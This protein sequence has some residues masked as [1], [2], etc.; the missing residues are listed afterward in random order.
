LFLPDLYCFQSSVK[1]GH[2]TYGPNSPQGHEGMYTVG[3][4]ESV[5]FFYGRE[6]PGL[7][8]SDELDVG[9]SD[10]ET[11]HSYRVAGDRKSLAGKYWY[12]GESNHVLFKTPAIEDDG[13]SFANSSEFKVKIDP[14][15]HG[16]RLRRRLDR[17]VNRQLANVYIDG[18][19]AIERPWYMVDYDKTYRDIRWADSDFEIPAKYT[20]GKS[21]ITVK[22]ENLG[23]VERPW[24]EFYYWV[25]SYQP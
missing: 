17:N 3:N 20:A 23:G 4:E 14:A 22:V 15:N 5:E 11:A 10:S 21:E 1:H 25:Y 13:V 6:K 19:K 2:Q 8:L 9:K 16:V 7:V 24:N 12:D 18:Q